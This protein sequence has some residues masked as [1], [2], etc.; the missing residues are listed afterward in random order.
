MLYQNSDGVYKAFWCTLT[1]FL[2]YF[3]H[4]G[5]IT[6]IVIKHDISKVVDVADLAGD[7][8]ILQQNGFV[9]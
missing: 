6:D 4:V 8:Y 1:A 9:W 2:K 7:Y 3:L 5:R